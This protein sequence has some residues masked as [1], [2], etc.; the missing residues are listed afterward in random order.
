[1]G[2][3]R[4]SKRRATIWKMMALRKKRKYEIVRQLIRYELVRHPPNTKLSSNNTVLSVRARGGN[5]TWH[6]L[7]LDTGNYSWSSEAVTRKD[8]YSGCR[9]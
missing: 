1:M 9:L 3:C 8:S 7:C 4:D 5:A 6:A 2:I